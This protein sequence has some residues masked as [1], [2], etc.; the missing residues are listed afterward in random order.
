MLSIWSHLICCRL[1]KTFITGALHFV[2]GRTTFYHHTDRDSAEKILSSGKIRQSNPKSTNDDAVFGP[3]TYGTKLGP[4][5]SKDAVARN[6][7]DGM[8]RY[9]ESKRDKAD[10]AFEFK[11]TTSKVE[12]HST[13]GRSVLKHKGDIKLTDV[14]DLKVHVRDDKGGYQTYKPNPK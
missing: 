8:T 6:N 1:V 3:G 12:D 9:W 5:V 2:S 14:K 4:D 13:P 10:V 11:V 7:Y